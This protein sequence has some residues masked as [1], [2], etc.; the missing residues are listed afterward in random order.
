MSILQRL[1]ERLAGTASVRTS[2]GARVPVLDSR[3]IDLTAPLPA[4]AKV[5]WFGAQA[6]ADSP[7]RLRRLLRRAEIATATDDAAM[8]GRLAVLTPRLAHHAERRIALQQAA[9]LTALS[10]PPRRD[11]PACPA[12]AHVV[13]QV[14]DFTEGGMEQVVIDL[15]QA[16]ATAKLRVTILVLGRTGTAATRATA[17]GLTLRRC[18]P[19][20]EAY[21]AFLASERVALVNA[22][23]STFGADLC[24]RAGV[25]FVQTVHN[26]Y[27][28]FGQA[29]RDTYRAADPHTRAYI[30]VSN[31]AARYCDVA[32]GLG[33]ERMLVIPNGCHRDYVRP[34][35][36]ADAVARV[37][38]ELGVPDAAP[39]FLNIASI[40]P[41]KAQHL[42]LDAFHAVRERCAD[43][44]LV[45]L[46]RPMD[47]RYAAA[48]VQRT[49]DLG[50]TDR[51]HWAGHRDDV[52]TVH[53]AAAALVIPSF[54]EGWSLA[55]TEA[56]LAGLPAVATD[57]GGASEQLEGTEGILLPAAADDLTAIDIH[58]L[59]ALLDAPNDRVRRALAD[60]LVEIHARRG[61][62]SPLPPDWQRLL[63]ECAYARYAQVFG[64]LLAGW[65]PAQARAFTE[66]NP[67]LLVEA[68]QA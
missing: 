3:R 8:A 68:G 27:M 7:Y 18:D 23:F 15:A 60:A 64:C 62:R 24:A 58:R 30:C 34:Q 9:E 65:T 33:A 4:G 51:V 16:L 11:A 48:Q 32:I 46:G 39:F 67:P 56:V 59:L 12:G 26:M 6:G 55:I 66:P 22:H 10:P 61:R 31:N 49:H 14:G 42:L 53:A 13:L 28:W 41:A 52:T 17:H 36:P 19:T 21:A 44:H 5:L 43:A 63:R 20:V 45:F 2:R 35:P 1:C 54:F 25:P 38:R 29:E 50:L 47:E 57:V 37:R 40:Q